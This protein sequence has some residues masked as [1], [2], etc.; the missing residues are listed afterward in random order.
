MDRIKWALIGAL[1]ALLI[2][3]VAE[4]RQPWFRCFDRPDY[5]YL[6]SEKACIPRGALVPA[7]EPGRV[8]G[9]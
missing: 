9:E 6:V 1:A 5:V 2:I 4:S 7:V 3:L 8:R